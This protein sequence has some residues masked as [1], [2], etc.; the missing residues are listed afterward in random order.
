MRKNVGLQVGMESVYIPPKEMLSNA[1]GFRSLYSNREVHFEEV[2]RD[3][4]DRAYLP[5]LRGTD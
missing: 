5:A 4:L 3:I 1:P 2:Y